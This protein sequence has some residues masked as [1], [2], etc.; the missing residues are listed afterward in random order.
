[1]E[2]AH[3][4]GT[5]QVPLTSAT[6]LKERSPHPRRLIVKPTCQCPLSMCVCVCGAIYL[7]RD[8]LLLSSFL[9]S[10]TVISRW[11]EAYFDDFECSS[12][13]CVAG[14]SPTPNSR[15][16]DTGGRCMCGTN[17]G[18]DIGGVD[19]GDDSEGADTRRRVVSSLL[20]T[21]PLRWRRSLLAHHRPSRAWWLT[22]LV[23]ARPVALL[24]VSRYQPMGPRML[25]IWGTP[26]WGC[27]V[28]PACHPCLP[29]GG[30]VELAC[31]RVSVVGQ[32]LW[33]AMAMVDRDVLHL[34]Q[35]SLKERKTF[36]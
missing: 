2:L 26:N 6:V 36:T 20:G 9:S 33:E 12:T 28:T 19:A 13:G 17:R 16:V 31:S 3:L 18:A 5:S 7:L 1:M 10:K 29:A 23:R 25:W 22:A 14:I 34:V 8:F 32:L 4:S 35:V 11:K 30:S 27:R 24:W 15:R 21:C